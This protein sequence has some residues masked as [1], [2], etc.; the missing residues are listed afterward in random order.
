MSL[1]KRLDEKV[2]ML[3]SFFRSK[4]IQLGSFLFC[5]FGQLSDQLTTQINI[6]FLGCVETNPYI[7]PIIASPI[8]IFVEIGFFSVV[9]LIPYTLTKITKHASP[10]M[11]MGFLFGMSKI[12]ASIHNIALWFWR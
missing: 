1:E 8:M 10:L 4:T 5:V 9:W 6:N 3:L 12:F 7:A 11:L 2:N